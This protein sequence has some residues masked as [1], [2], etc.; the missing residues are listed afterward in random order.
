MSCGEAIFWMIQVDDGGVKIHRHGAGS[1]LPLEFTPAS[2]EFVPA[3][4]AFRERSV[5]G[6]V[7]SRRSP[8]FAVGGGIKALL[9]PAGNLLASLTLSAS[10]YQRYHSTQTGAISTVCAA[11]GRLPLAIVFGYF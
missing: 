8:L 1:G 2:S 10:E 7:P 11:P 3:R 4:S 6:R 9:N 5:C